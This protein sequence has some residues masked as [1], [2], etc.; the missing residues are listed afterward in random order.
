MPNQNIN[1]PCTPFNVDLY[2]LSNVEKEN[3]TEN[4]RKLSTSLREI[5]TKL[6]TTIFIE[7]VLGTQFKL[8]HSQMKDIARI[9]RDIILSD[10]YLGD[11]VR[12][13]QERL[14]V[15]EQKAK[16]ISSMIVSQLFAPV[17]EEL[18]KAQMEKYGDKMGAQA[19]PQAQNS[20]PSQVQRA[21]PLQNNTQTPPANMPGHYSPP[22]NRQQTV[23]LKNKLQS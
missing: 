19:T 14:Q 7:E 15:D 17:M 1:Y 3:Y 18:K 8:D 10:I 22:E 9:I 5:A 6:E 21:A 11:I 13:V 2:S 4:F 16:E 23:N 20:G 12:T